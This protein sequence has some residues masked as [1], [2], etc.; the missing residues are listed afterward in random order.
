MSIQVMWRLILTMYVI[1]NVVIVVLSL[2]ACGTQKQ[3][4]TEHGPL[5]YHTIT[6]PTLQEIE[7]QFLTEKQTL[8]AKHSGGG[9]PHYTPF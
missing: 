4:N 7:G 6:H 9:G 5:V 8:G 3:M 1:L 2:A